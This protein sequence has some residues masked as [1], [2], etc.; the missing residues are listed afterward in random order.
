MTDEYMKALKAGE[1]EYKARVAAGEYPY[2]AAL[3]DMLPDCGSMPQ[4]R[5]GIM[6][7]PTGLIAGTKTRARQNSFAPDFMPLLE[8]D[9]EFAAKWISL[10]N[11]QITEGFNDPIRVYEYLHRFYVQEGNKRVSVSRFLDMPTI[12]AFILRQEKLNKALKIPR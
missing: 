9:T 5:L 6:E 8:G 10:Y 11:A 2:L 12:S 1:K 4:R 7:I 3:D